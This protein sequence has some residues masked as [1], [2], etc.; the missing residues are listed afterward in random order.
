MLRNFKLANENVT[1]VATLLVLPDCYA[2]VYTISMVFTTCT[3]QC[4]QPKK[5]KKIKVFAENHLIILQWG[6]GRVWA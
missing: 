2:S 3:L 4:T 6:G 1:S 5:I